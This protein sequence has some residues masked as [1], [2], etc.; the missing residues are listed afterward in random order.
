ML[1]LS[2]HLLLCEKKVTFLRQI[3]KWVTYLQRIKKKSDLFAIK[4]IKTDLI[5]IWP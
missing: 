1:T 3:S 4:V 5:A 2:D